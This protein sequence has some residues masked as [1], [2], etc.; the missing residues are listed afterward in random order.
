[1]IDPLDALGAPV[2]P[3][4][5]DPSFAARLRRALRQALGGDM[6]ETGAETSAADVAWPPTL[7]PYIAVRDARRALDWYPDVFGAERRGEPYV[8]ADGS[9]GHAELGIGDAVLMLSEGSTQ[10][11]V[12]PPLGGGTFSHTLHLQ[13]D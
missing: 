4:D 1:M 13:V 2:T 8:M 10:V 6:T 9:I 12:Q 5:P 11:P 3:I 7:T